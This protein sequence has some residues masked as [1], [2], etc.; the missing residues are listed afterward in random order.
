MCVRHAVLI[1]S[2]NFFLFSLNRS[3]TIIYISIIFI[4]MNA[5]SINSEANS[6]PWSKDQEP[7][8]IYR[9]IEH[10]QMIDIQYYCHFMHANDDGDDAVLVSRI[11]YA[12]VY[13]RIQ[14]I[15]YITHARA[16]VCIVLTYIM[17][18]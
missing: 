15:R 14:C 5:V 13:V 17:S 18:A 4:S 6:Y 11:Y 8:D 2:C 7:Q 3:Y 1:N 16:R 10:I 9:D 12:H